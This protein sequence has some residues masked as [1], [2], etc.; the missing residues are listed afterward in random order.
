[1]KIESGIPLPAR[2]SER[3]E[4]GPLPLGEMRVDDSIRV[5]AKNPREL[6]RKYHACRIRCQRFSK[7]HPRLKFKVAKD[8]DEKGPYLRIF[9]VRRTSRDD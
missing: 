2:L 8:S 3:V 6:D 9:R 7:K 4:V 1:M 5:D